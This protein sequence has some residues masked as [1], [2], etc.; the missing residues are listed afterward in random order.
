MKAKSF[1]R[2]AAPCR[3]AEGPNA[4]TPNQAGG[5][6]Q[7]LPAR[8]DDVALEQLSLNALLYQVLFSDR[9]FQR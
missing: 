3:T 9:L 7:R 8:Q 6:L 1:F 5:D 4:S 2:K